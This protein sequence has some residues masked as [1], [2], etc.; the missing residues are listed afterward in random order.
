MKKISVLTLASVLIAMLAGIAYAALQKGDQSPE[1]TLPYL[2]EAKR[3]RIADFIGAEPTDAKKVL[4]LSF[5]ASYCKPCIK[6]LPEL[7]KLHQKYKDKGLLVVDVNIDQAN[8]DKVK[9]IITN[10]KVTFPVLV[11][12]F[13]V[14]ARNYGATQLPK[15][16]IIDG[17]GK[18]ILIN[19][20]YSEEIFKRIEDQIKELLG[21]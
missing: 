10:A 18:V 19:A 4:V 20:G 21:K 8:L 15:M 11:D 2:L 17:T 7:E 5:F 12:R 14:V 16:F 3:L 13:N 1:F 6:E 9:E